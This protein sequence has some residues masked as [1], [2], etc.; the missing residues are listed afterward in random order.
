MADG[1]VPTPLTG[2][3]KRHYETGCYGHTHLRMRR[4]DFDAYPRPPQ[5]E[6]SVSPPLA[7]LMAIPV[8][9]DVTLPAGAW[10]LVDNSTRQVLRTGS[11]TAEGRDEVA[12]P[13]ASDPKGADH[14]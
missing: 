7:G 5:P 1:V 13:N 10:Q 4:E 2:L 9:V 12:H 3:I 14:D 11:M 6:F 8:V